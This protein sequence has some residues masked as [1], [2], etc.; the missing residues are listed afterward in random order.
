MP[1]FERVVRYVQE[2]PWAIRPEALGAILDV[3]E[4]RA[5]G[6]KLTAEE[7]E[8]RLD[9]KDSERLPSQTGKVAVIPIYGTIFP[10]ANMFSEFSGGTSLQK[11]T[12]ALTAA[13]RDPEISTI[14]L[15]VASPGGSVDLLPETAEVIR[16][17]KT[18]TV[19]V[20]NTQSA[21][22]A[23]WLTSQADEVAVSP[24]GEVGSIGVFTAHQDV[25]G[26]EKQLGV[27]TTLIS[28]GKYKTEGHPFGPLDPEARAAIQ[29]KVDHYYDLFV[30]DVARG[31]GVSAKAVRDGFG[32]G[33]MVTAVEAVREGMADRVATLDQIISERSDGSPPVAI[34]ASAKLVDYFANPNFGIPGTDDRLRYDPSAGRW[35]VPVT[36]DGD[37]IFGH[38]AP[39]G[40][41]L[42]GRPERCVT[43]PEGDL[44]GFMR[45][46]APAAG[47]L[48][49]GVIVLGDDGH[50]AE[51]VGVIEATRHYDK[52]GR[53]GADVRVGRDAY[54]IWF[55]GMIRPGLSKNDRYALA[56]SDVSGHWESD[57]RGMPTLVGLPAVNV[58]GFPKGYLTAAE[59]NSGIAAAASIEAD[60]FDV[61]ADGEEVPCVESRLTALED[62]VGVLLS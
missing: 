51:G 4:F 27:R 55:S 28:A 33:R 57:Q 48:R 1:D 6:G 21:S 46:Y 40:V 19:A 49:T 42:R 62:A 10:R 60:C 54:G 7:I 22:A 41:C 5:S 15:D 47:G 30:T 26:A 39:M 9:G 25:S 12:A 18:A 17:L 50:A 31:R 13:D 37:H 53:A 34:A 20:A 56:S 43:P 44:E 52:T 16:G 58:G 2:M 32:Q 45:G 59:V 61:S 11:L 29:S 36:V 38:V 24:S 8:A 14:V 35:S 3:L 23:Y